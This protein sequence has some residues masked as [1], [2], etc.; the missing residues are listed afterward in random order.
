MVWGCNRG[1]A[2]FAAWMSFSR[3]LFGEC[4]QRL[5][6]IDDVGREHFAGVGSEVE[7]VVGDAGRYQKAV[8]GVQGQRSLVAY[9]HA[10]G[11]G[12][13]VTDFF[14]WVGMPAGLDSD[15]DF[16]E[17]LHDVASGNRR[18]AALDFSPLQFSRERVTRLW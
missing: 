7:S 3:E 10:D 13:E 12:Q 4:R 2:I 6:G 8:A 9:F 5:V 11:P 17:D 14:A 18:C 16:G 1:D 15:R